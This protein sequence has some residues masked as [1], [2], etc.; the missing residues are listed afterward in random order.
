MNNKYMRVWMLRLTWPR[1]TASSGKIH[2]GFLFLQLMW[3]RS[4]GLLR[5]RINCETESP[6]VIGR[7]PLL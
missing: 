2:W 4:F 3:I 6:S 7:T 1:V 5:F